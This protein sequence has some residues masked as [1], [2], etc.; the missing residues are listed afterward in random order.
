MP[1]TI[2]E[3]DKA[4]YLHNNHFCVIWKSDLRS[5]P[6]NS[7]AS[8]KVNFSKAI[9][10]LELNF[11]YVNNKVTDANVTKFKEYK[12]NP[13]KVDSQLNNVIVYDIETYNKDRAI[14]YAMSVFIQ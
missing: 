11:K 12:F 9:E 2:T 1:R 7:W 8:V 4:L 13:K 6:A 14:P 5:G 3:K 10:E